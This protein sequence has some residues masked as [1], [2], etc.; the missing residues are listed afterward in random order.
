[1]TYIWPCAQRTAHKRDNAIDRT[2]DEIAST[3]HQNVQHSLDKLE[4]D[5]SAVATTITALLAADAA[6]GAHNRRAASYGYALLVLSL[7]P[8]LLAAAYLLHRLQPPPVVRARELAPQ[9]YALAI[10]AGE[11]LRRAIPTGASPPGGIDPAAASLPGSIKPI[12][13]HPAETSP[14]L[15]LAFRSPDLAPASPPAAGPLTLPHFVASAAAVFL[16]LQLASRYFRRYRPQYSGRELSGLRGTRD[17]VTG[18]VLERKRRLY[19]VYLD[20]CSSGVG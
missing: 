9:M 18:E 3:I 12:A 11:A 16:L 20:Q 4:E 6:A 8:L 5:A 13:S 1:M 19:Q 2:C 17:Y 7:Q 10:A 15:N 14:A